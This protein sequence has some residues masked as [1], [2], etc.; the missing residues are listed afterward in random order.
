MVASPEAP[1]DGWAGHCALL[2][3]LSGAGDPEAQGLQWAEPLCSQDSEAFGIAEE[4]WHSGG[5]VAVDVTCAFQNIDGSQS[6]DT[7]LEGASEVTSSASE[8]WGDWWGD[9]AVADVSA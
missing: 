7:T 1:A 4:Y 6:T 8:S 5:C 3:G 2:W 9:E